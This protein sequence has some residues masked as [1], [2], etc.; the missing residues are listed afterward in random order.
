MDFRAERQRPD[1]CFSWSD[2]ED[3]NHV[4]D[5]LDLRLEVRVP[6]TSGLIQHE[7]YVGRIAAAS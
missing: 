2:L 4:L 6:D 5:K 3:V 7:D 1:P